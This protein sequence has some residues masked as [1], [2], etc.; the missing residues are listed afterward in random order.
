MDWSI[1]RDPKS[2]CCCDL[3]CASWSNNSF[4]RHVPDAWNQPDIQWGKQHCFIWALIL[5]PYP[6]IKSISSAAPYNTIARSILHVDGV[7]S[8]A[9]LSVADRVLAE[10]DI[11]LF[12]LLPAFKTACLSL[13]SFQ[14]LLCAP[15]A[16]L[17]IQMQE[18]KSYKQKSFNFW[19][20]LVH[21][22]LDEQSQRWKLQN[23]L[24][25]CYAGCHCTSAAYGLL[26]LQQSICQLYLCVS[27]V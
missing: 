6:W 23:S 22:V 12:S 21:Y 27:L 9:C 7:V 13:N 10:S 1:S 2:S 24:Y 25:S 11:C 20:L 18:W 26:L 16:L 15:S 8:Q 4:R 17:F 14:F 5:D 3:C 19:Q